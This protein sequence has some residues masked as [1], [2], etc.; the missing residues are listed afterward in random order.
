M[1]PIKV[2]WD[3]KVEYE[4]CTVGWRGF[5]LHLIDPTVDSVEL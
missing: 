1:I 4:K 3:V 2:C 5:T